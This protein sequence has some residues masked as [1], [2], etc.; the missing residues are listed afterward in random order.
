MKPHRIF[1]AINL[2]EEAKEELLAY[3]NK[4]PELLASPTRLDPAERAGGPAR[5]T[6]KENLHLTLAFLGNTSDQELEEVCSVIK[7]VGARHQPLSIEFNK[8]V[9]GPLRLRSGQAPR[10]IWAVAEP[11]SSAD[12]LLELQKDVV[13]TLH[14]EQE[15]NFTPHLTLARLKA[16]ELQG[17][18]LEEMPDVNEEVSISFEVK[19]IEVMESRL[20]R[21]GAEYTTIQSFM[22][23]E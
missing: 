7:Q 13:Q 2:P 14:V 12:K 4:W 23:K 20:R 22:L 15:Q 6:T 3:K 17:M 1:I 18:E 10:M 9:Y 11:A 16:F 5:W 21:S 19:S 8:I